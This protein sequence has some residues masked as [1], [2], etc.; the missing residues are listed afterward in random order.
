MKKRV[1][2][3]MLVLGMTLSL[4]ACGSSNDKK[5][6]DTKQRQLTKIARRKG[7]L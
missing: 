1:L 4:A 3:L 2:A 6:D 7:Q 5:S